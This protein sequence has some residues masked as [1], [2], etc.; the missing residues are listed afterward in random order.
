MDLSKHKDPETSGVSDDGVK[1]TLLSQEKT[2]NL[3]TLF[4][5]YAINKKHSRIYFESNKDYGFSKRRVVL[6][7]KPNGD[8]DIVSMFRKYG[9]SKTNVMY[10]REHVSLAVRYRAGK[11][12]YACG[13]KFTQ[14]T[15]TNL[16]HFGQ[17]DRLK[18]EAFLIERFPWLRNVKESS[19]MQQTSLNTLKTNKLFNEK[20]YLR[21]KY[22]TS[23]TNVMNILTHFKIYRY[24]SNTHKFWTDYKDHIVNLENLNP[25]L[26]QS[27]LF[28]DTLN[29]AKTLGYKVNVG[30]SRN[31]LKLE[32]DKWAKEVVE[33]L[34][35]YE[36]Y[37]ELKI[38]RVYLDFARYS[39]YELLT[40]NHALIEEGKVMGHCVG[41]YSSSVDTGACAI[42][43]VNGCT[44][45]ARFGKTWATAKDTMKMF[46]NQYMAFANTTPP[47]GA[48]EQVRDMIDRF[49]EA[50][51][52]E[53]YIKELNIKP[54]SIDI[55]A[56][57]LNPF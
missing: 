44:L 46:L 18:I 21:F 26:T 25:D 24:G 31:R 47:K 42:Y 40:S 1:W 56:N 3:D 9:I 41:T 34:L 13:K 50:V 28:E 52:T 48:M 27:Q 12:Y 45:E 2:S 4:D 32:H 36:P 7:E 8:F 23:Y 55:F 16:N 39:G 54:T 15:Y 5:I 43:R 33:V 19:H 30:W 29:M 17:A 57:D 38:A 53:D 14:F 35:E 37:R 49:N 11:F 51:V 20:K 6:F 10:H 22:K